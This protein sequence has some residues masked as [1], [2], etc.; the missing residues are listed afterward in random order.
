LFKVTAAVA[1][2]ASFTVNTDIVET[3]IADELKELQAAIAA[4][5]T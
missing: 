3:T 2:G 5:Q 4:I 1:S